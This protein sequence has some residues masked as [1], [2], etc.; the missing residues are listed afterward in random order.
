MGT[1]SAGVGERKAAGTVSVLGKTGAETGL[2]SQSGLLV[3]GDAADGNRCPQQ[4]GGDRSHAAAG[5]HDAGQHGAG[6]VENAQQFVVPVARFQIHEHGA[7][8]VGVVGDVDFAGGQIPDQ[9]GID[10]A[11]E[12]F[13]VAGTFHG[14][15]YVVEDPADL[16]PG[17]VRIN[18]QACLRLHEATIERLLQLIAEVS[19]PAT[20]PNNRRSNGFAGLLVPDNGRLALIGNPAGGDVAGRNTNLRQ[21]GPGGFQLCPPDGHRVLLHPARMR[22]ETVERYRVHGDTFTALIV[23]SGAGAGGSFVE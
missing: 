4:R 8:S 16:A 9:P 22:V 15:G 6:Y 19:S 21:G 10:V 18:Y 11:E 12:Q 17:K 2:A 23:K 7:G 5:G 14:T 1:N 13:A 20:L 3:T